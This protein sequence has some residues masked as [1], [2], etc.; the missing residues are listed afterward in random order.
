MVQQAN[1]VELRVLLAN[2]V[3][4]SLQFSTVDLGSNCR[5]VRQQFEAVYSIKSPPSAQHDLLFMDF[6]FHERTRHFI[7]SVPRTFVGVVDVEDPF[8]ISSDNGVQPVESAASG[9]Q[10]SADVQPS[11]AAAVVQCMWEPLNELFHRSERSQSIAQ[12]GQGTAKTGRQY[13][14]PSYGCCSAR[15]FSS[16][17]DIA[18][19]RPG[20]GSS[21]SF[22]FLALKCWN[23]ARTDRSEGASVPNT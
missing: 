17:N 22:L 8:F 14:T 12:D 3:G 18:V 21:S 4:Q 6:T 16:S 7:A 19:G 9:E 20:R 5:V 2:L 15:F 10:L 1:V 11:T 23:Q 13:H